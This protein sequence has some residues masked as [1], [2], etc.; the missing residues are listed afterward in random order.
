M[1]RLAFLLM[2]TSCFGMNRIPEPEYVT[3]HLGNSIAMDDEY[4]CQMAMRIYHKKTSLEC[5]PEIKP[6]LLRAL[7][8]SRHNGESEKFVTMTKELTKEDEDF[9]MSQVNKAVAIA[10]KD[11]KQ[12]IESRIPK[13]DAAFYVGAVGLGCTIITTAVTLAATLT[14]KCPK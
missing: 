7:D 12:Q 5:S 11:Q 3:I 1:K 14:G 4:Y 10:L 2:S 13:K 8:Y 9:L 6:Y